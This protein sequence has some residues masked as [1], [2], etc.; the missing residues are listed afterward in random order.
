MRVHLQTLIA[1]AVVFPATIAV[2]Y[3]ASVVTSEC[4]CISGRNCVFSCGSGGKLYVKVQ[5]QNSDY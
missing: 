5:L 4:V 3:V 2:L 1:R